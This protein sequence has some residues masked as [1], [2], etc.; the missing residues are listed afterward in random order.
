MFQL[1]TQNFTKGFFVRNFISHYVFLNLDCFN[2]NSPTLFRWYSGFE[3]QI[4]IFT[5]YS[6]FFTD[7][8][9]SEISSSSVKANHITMHAQ[10]CR[11]AWI[12]NS[13]I[14]NVFFRGPIKWSYLDIQRFHKRNRILKK[15]FIDEKCGYN[16]LRIQ[17]V[18]NVL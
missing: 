17:Y 4:F 16:N 2:L 13:F 5:K 6:N 18:I 8:C 1:Y 7:I 9:I 10:I 11:K 14:H 15:L 12:G 3:K